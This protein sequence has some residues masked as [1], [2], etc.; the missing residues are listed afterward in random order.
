MGMG[1]MRRMVLFDGSR[2]R[3]FAAVGVCPGIGLCF[4]RGGNSAFRYLLLG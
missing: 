2:L 4:R 3:F 1:R